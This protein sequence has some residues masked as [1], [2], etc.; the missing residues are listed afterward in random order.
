MPTDGA[1]TVSA[2]ELEGRM[3]VYDPKAS[4]AKRDNSEVPRARAE[5]PSPDAKKKKGN[6]G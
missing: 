1:S 4:G 2:M 5:A 6:R 3:V